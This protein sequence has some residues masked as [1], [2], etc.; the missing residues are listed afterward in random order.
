MTLAHH[1]SLP[2]AGGL[3]LLVKEA[4]THVLQLCRW[5]ISGTAS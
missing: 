1:P 3:K 4:S 2:A 5:P